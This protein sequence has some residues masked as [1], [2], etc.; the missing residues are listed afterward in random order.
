[1][2]AGLPAFS[3]CVWLVERRRDGSHFSHKPLEGLDAVLDGRIDAYV[4]DFGT[5]RYLVNSRQLNEIRVVQ[6]RNAAAH[7]ALAVRPGSP[8]LEPINV[9]LLEAVTGRTWRSTIHRWLGPD[10]DTAP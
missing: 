9:A 2:I 10:L 1:M 6:I 5:L 3:I 4:A 8:L 7:F